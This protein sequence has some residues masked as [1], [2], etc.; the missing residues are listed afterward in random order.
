MS[1]CTQPEQTPGT[2]LGGVDG[3]DQDEGRRKGDEGSEVPFCFFTAQGNPLETFQLS[4]GLLNTRPAPV[5]CLCKYLGDDPGVFPE[6]DDRHRTIFAC[7]FSIFGT[8]IALV[9]YHRARQNIRPKVQQS[10]GM[11]AV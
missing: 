1:F 6:R 5:E 9:R 7:D 10:L 8:V 4:D 2:A 11:W 3:F